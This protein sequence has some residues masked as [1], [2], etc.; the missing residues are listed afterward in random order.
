MPSCH[1]GRRRSCPALRRDRTHG[2]PGGSQR[3]EHALVVA[4]PAV[5]HQQVTGVLEVGHHPRRGGPASCRRS[6]SPPAGGVPPPTPAAAPR[7]RAGAATAATGLPGPASPARSPG[8]RALPA[9]G[10]A[11]AGSSPPTPPG[12]GPQDRAAGDGRLRR[13]R[14]SSTT[15]GTAPAPTGACPAARS[16]AATFVGGWSL[17]TTP[18][19]ASTRPR[20]RNLLSCSSSTPRTASARRS[21]V[22]ACTSSTRRVCGG[23]V[24]APG[25]S[26]TRARPV[27]GAR[28]QL[29][30]QLLAGPPGVQR[31]AH[32]LGRQPPGV[33]GLAVRDLVQQG[34][35]A[36][37][38]AAGDEG[39]AVG[40][41]DDVLLR[42]RQVLGEQ[43][44]RTGCALVGSVLLVVV[45]GLRPPLLGG[46]HRGQPAPGCRRRAARAAPAPAG[47]RRSATPGRPDRPGARPTSR[48]RRPG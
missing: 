34:P 43:R 16:A 41:Q 47:A 8:P 23:G 32:A 15:G 30:Q 35:Q 3:D 19:A 40:L 22:S 44:G 28:R 39:R 4:Q 45:A 1:A 13:S 17:T 27:L 11:P 42:R 10:R 29:G 33:L 46:R 26:T 24:S 5:A 37:P 14:G 21:T 48:A 12:L 9:A 38:G 20:E 6:R 18:G 25:R 7:R 2:G 36:G 31:L